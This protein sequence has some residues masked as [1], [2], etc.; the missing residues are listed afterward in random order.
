[1]REYR[2][3]QTYPFIKSMLSHPSGSQG[4]RSAKRHL[5]ELQTAY[6]ALLREHVSMW[7]HFV[8][9][10]SSLYAPNTYEW[11]GECGNSALLLEK[12]IHEIL[13]QS[14][15]ALADLEVEPH[16]SPEGQKAVGKVL[17]YGRVTSILYRLHLRIAKLEKEY[18]ADPDARNGLESKKRSPN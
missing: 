12:A 1:M 18:G 10:S 7:S 6:A 2:S 17:A 9:H 4:P 5:A 14:R 8:M 16:D 11:V 3:R 15:E 13:S